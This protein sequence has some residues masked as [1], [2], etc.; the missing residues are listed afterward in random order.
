[1]RA[2]A[3]IVGGG[4]AGLIAARELADKGFEVKVFEEH[5]EIGVPNHCAGILS[6]KGLD[7]IGVSPKTE[8]IRHEIRGGTIFSPE[9]DAIKIDSGRTRAY[10]IDRE[11]FD[12]HLAGKAHDAGAE[13]ERGHRIREFIVKRG[14]VSGIQGDTNIAA[15][16]VIDAEGAS[17]VLA[18]KMGLPRPVEGVLAGVNIDIPDAELEPGIAEVWLDQELAEGLFAWAVPTEDDGARCGLATGKG[19]PLELLR[20]FIVR[21]FDL[22]ECGK[23][24]V[25][26]V[27]T[28]GPVVKT[29]SSGLLLVGDV[30]GQTKPT[31]GGGVILGGMCAVMAA[32][33][34]SEALESEDSSA[35]FL[36]R[37]EDAWRGALG[38]EFSTMLNVRRFLNSVPDERIERLFSSL[39]AANLKPVLESL[40]KEGDMD[41]QS[42]VLRK[43]L[44]HPGMF[45]ILV[46]SLGNLAFKEA[47]S[48]LR[49]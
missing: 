33:T 29:F 19:D 10:I 42:G 35:G 25:W 16:I 4:P 20:R 47:R 21:R 11:A 37:Y 18:R 23:P 7:R 30:A 28:S 40:I 32:E 36:A 1:L 22:S 41:L 2:E 46:K 12:R 5:R 27:L 15:R 34:A 38:K 6:V 44:T 49:I 17:G 43:T 39:K 8:Y 48:L 26:P 14:I 3:A 9:G 45:G 31:T 13:I 24:V